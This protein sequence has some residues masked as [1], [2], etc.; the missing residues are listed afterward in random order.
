MSDFEE[1][2]FLGMGGFANV[3]KVCLWAVLE[4]G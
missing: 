2:K 4:R 1:I 3:V